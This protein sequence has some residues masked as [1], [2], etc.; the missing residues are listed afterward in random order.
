MDEKG[1]L[2]LR[3][4]I[5]FPCDGRKRLKC[6]YEFDGH[7][8][9]FGKETIGRGMGFFCKDCFAEFCAGRSWDNAITLCQTITKDNLLALYI[10]IVNPEIE[11]VIGDG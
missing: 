9:R 11:G 5:H 1:G 7:D 6:E 3:K 4:L 10:T 2:A 8:L